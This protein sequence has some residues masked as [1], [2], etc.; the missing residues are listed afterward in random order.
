MSADLS[1]TRCRNV[2]VRI[3]VSLQVGWV[4]NDLFD[5]DGLLHNHLGF[6]DRVQ[7]SHLQLGCVQVDL[8]DEDCLPHLLQGDV[9]HTLPEGEGPRE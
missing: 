9:L 1:S 4:Q 3:G 8:F 5:E 2:C 7:G 6:R